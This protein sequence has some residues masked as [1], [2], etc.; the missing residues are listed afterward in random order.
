[1]YWQKRFDRENPCQK[2]EDQIIE[3]RKEHK[4]FGYRR[5]WGEL[6]NKGVQINKKKVQRIMNKYNIKPQYTRKK[7]N[8]SYKRIEANVKP[9]L[10][11]RKF[12][13][14]KENKI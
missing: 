9:N 1:M 2:E 5:V 12:N 3:I 11:K 10:V 6:K 14:D 7:K 8:P 13:V 4:D